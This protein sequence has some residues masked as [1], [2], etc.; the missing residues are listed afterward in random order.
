MYEQKEQLQQAK[1]VTH[2]DVMLKKNVN[3]KE[4][5]V[6]V[7]KTTVAVHGKQVSTR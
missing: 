2:N 4:N 6:P 1:T 5:T 3:K 7:A